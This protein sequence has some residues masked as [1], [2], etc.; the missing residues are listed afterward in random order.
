MGG[1][2]FFVSAR[3]D[4]EGTLGRMASRA[5]VSGGKR[6]APRRRAQGDRPG[7]PSALRPR[8]AITHDNRFFWE[9][10]KKGKLLIQRCADCGK[11]R[12]PP[13]PIC[14]SCRSYAW[15]AL[16]SSGR[17]AVYSFVLHRHPVIPPFPS[18]HPVALIE[19]EEGTR[20]VSDLVGV[21]PKQVRIGMRVRVEF[22]AVDPGLVLPQFRPVED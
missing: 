4:L 5:K 12:H 18:P 13:T 9:G 19:L 21:D 1:A 8:P 2:A 15:K 7:A 17:G 20:L 22:N 14:P 16:E 10:V 11:L 6:A 3:V